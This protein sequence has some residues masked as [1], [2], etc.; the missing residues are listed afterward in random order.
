MTFLALA[1]VFNSE[2][3]TP[4]PDKPM[5]RQFQRRQG[6]DRTL[7]L[8]CQSVL[9]VSPVY[10]GSNVLLKLLFIGDIVGE[11]GLAFVEEALPDLRAAQDPALVIA[12]AENVAITGP[13]PATGCGMTRAALKRLFH[14]GVD[15]ITGGNHSWD[16][17]EAAEV[18]AHARVLRP[19]NYGFGA[20]GKGVLELERGGATFGVVNLASRTALPRADEPYDALVQQLRAWEDTGSVPDHV[21]IDFHGESVSEKQTFAWSVAGRVSAVLGTHTH[22]ATFDTRVLPGGT[23]FVS[24]VGMTGPTGG[25]QGYDPELFVAAL[26][27]R[28]PPQQRASFASGPVTL[29]AVWVTLDRTGATSIERVHCNGG[30]SWG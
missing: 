17:P 8:L 23:A 18:S 11:A 6:N 27:T 30:S 7:T 21:I 5:S 10:Q 9:Y 16:G 25:I 24:D 28:L 1:P 3:V 4:Q 20:P 12:N 29:G 15:V 22:V 26:R 13:S 19:L 14:L 2:R